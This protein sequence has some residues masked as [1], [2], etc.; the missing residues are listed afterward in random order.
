MRNLQTGIREEHFTETGQNPRVVLAALLQEG[1]GEA[2]KQASLDELESLAE[3]AGFEVV[4]VITQQRGM[5]SAATYLGEGKLREL[6]EFAEANEIELVIFDNE[7]SPSQIKNIERLTG[8]RAFDRSMLILEIF[9][10][11][12]VTREGRLQVEMAQLKYTLPRL[13]GKGVELS[14]LGGGGGMG[15]RRG[16]GETILELQRRRARDRIAALREEIAALRRT[17]Q[18]QRRARSRANLPRIAVMGYTNAGKSTLLNTLTDAGVLAQDKLFA[19]LDPTTRR[20]TLPSG[21]QLL[22]TD[23]V[24]FISNLPH[25][26][27]EAF[28]S[29]LEEVSQADLLLH[30][31]DISNPDCDRQMEICRSLVEELGAGALPMIT[32][33]NKMD[34]GAAAPLPHLRDAVPISALTGEGIPELLALIE[35]KLDEGRSTASFLIPYDRA[36]L[37]QELHEQAIVAEIDY[38][39]QGIFVKA[40]GTSAV[41][42]RMK[43]YRIG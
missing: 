30:V 43:N 21:A 33:L 38:R 35:R 32:A 25:H 42:G 7:L 28:A 8:C 22:L 5:P 1:A 39:E 18:E 16:K 15:A 40:R 26:L 37:V 34:R 12:A 13:T 3:T 2:A 9:N 6:K 36:G 10:L 29:T 4:G 27:I 20:L 23:T 14:R 41:L 19:T 31:V 11:H 17:R 24:G